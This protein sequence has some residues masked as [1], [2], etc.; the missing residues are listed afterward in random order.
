MAAISI[1]DKKNEGLNSFTHAKIEWADG[2]VRQ[3]W[4]RGPD[5]GTFTSTVAAEVTARLARNEGRP[6]AYT[7]GGLFGSTLAT[8][9]GCEY[10]PH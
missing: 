5:G 6:G 9:L 2:S 4:L 3:G 8:S 10:L 7:P 1:P